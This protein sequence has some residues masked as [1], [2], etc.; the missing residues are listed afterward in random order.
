MDGSL[1]ED[2]VDVCDRRRATA[3]VP[4]LRGLYLLIGSREHESETFG[5]PVGFISRS[6]CGL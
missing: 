3:D 4:L 2:A 5:N 6:G 1:K